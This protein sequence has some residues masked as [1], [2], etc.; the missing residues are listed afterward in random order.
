MLVMYSFD[1]LKDFMKGY[2]KKLSSSRHLNA[3]KK[4]CDQI[5]LTEGWINEVTQAFI[6]KDAEFLTKNFVTSEMWR[7]F[8]KESICAFANSLG[9]SVPLKRITGSVMKKVIKILT[10][11]PI[12]ILDL[13]SE[14]N[15]TVTRLRRYAGQLSSVN[16][17]EVDV[18]ATANK[19]V[20][21]SFRESESALMIDEN[22]KGLLVVK[23][24]DENGPTFLRS[25][26]SVLGQL[27][28]QLNI[29]KQIRQL[30]A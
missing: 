3:Y 25:Y 5:E 10:G 21:Q 22:K 26:T 13:H 7:R 14:R 9:F 8:T 27:I 16:N 30:E 23:C 4:Y 6:K 17:S 1:K 29:E 20:P 2:V 12:T 28:R 19:C 24:D 15:R 11:L 18:I